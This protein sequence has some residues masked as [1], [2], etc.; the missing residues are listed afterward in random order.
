MTLHSYPKLTREIIDIESNVK[1]RK[2]Q[3][4]LVRKKLNLL[5]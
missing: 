3:A 2:T 1:F 5:L 4:A